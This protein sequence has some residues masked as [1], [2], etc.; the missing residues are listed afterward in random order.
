MNTIEVDEKKL[1]A[2]LGIPLIK[3]CCSHLAENYYGTSCNYGESEH[4]SFKMCQFCN[5]KNVEAIKEWL[6]KED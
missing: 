4:L 5:F 2:V 3:S 6:R 1:D